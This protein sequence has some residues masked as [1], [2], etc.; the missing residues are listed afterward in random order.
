MDDLWFYINCVDFLVCV[1]VVV[2]VWCLCGLWCGVCVGVCVCVMCVMCVCGVVRVCGVC[3]CDVWCVYMVSG[4]VCVWCGM[5]VFVYVDW[6]KDITRRNGNTR[7]RHV[8][9]SEYKIS[10]YIL[11]GAEPGPSRQE[12]RLRQ[13]VVTWK[14]MSSGILCRA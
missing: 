14:F 10:Q 3:V 5:C 1:G 2:W 8:Q 13:G 11:G 6:S 12:V 4:V 9:V 7:S